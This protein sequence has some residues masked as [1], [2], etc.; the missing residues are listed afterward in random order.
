MCEMANGGRQGSQLV[1]SC[2]VNVAPDRSAFTT[3]LVKEKS[4]GSLRIRHL[5]SCVCSAEAIWSI[6]P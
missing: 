5:A 3:H 6:R 1:I 2:M 4:G